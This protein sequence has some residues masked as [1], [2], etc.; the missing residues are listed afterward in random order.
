MRLCCSKFYPL[1][2]ALLERPAS[3][4]L[5]FV[6]FVKCLFSAGGLGGAGRA[7][8]GDGGVARGSRGCGV[9]GRLACCPCRPAG[10]AAAR[11]RS[12]C[13]AALLGAGK[14]FASTLLEV[15]SAPCSGLSAFAPLLW[16]CRMPPGRRA[17]CG[18]AVLGA[19]RHLLK[20][21]TLESCRSCS[22][23]PCQAHLL[24]FPIV[25]IK[26]AIMPANESGTVS[27]HDV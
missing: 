3:Q 25:P 7:C 27:L 12:V 22:W 21:W 13:G 19:G 15:C 16:L 1:D 6:N 17:L 11:R 4:K 24:H 2:S 10:R 14:P 18:A 8:A 26:T 5:G 20:P 23:I 9:G